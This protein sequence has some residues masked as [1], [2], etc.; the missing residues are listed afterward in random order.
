MT[1]CVANGN[2]QVGIQAGSG[3]TINACAAYDNGTV[4]IDAS[5]GTTV[6]NCGVYSNGTDGI[7]ASLACVIKNNSVYGNTEDDIEVTTDCLVMNNTC[8]SAGFNTGD[9]AGIHVTSSRNRIE[10]NNVSLCDRGIQVAQPNNVI[11]NNSVTRNPTTGTAMNYVIAA[12]NQVEILLTFLPETISIPATVRLSGDL[13]GI[14]GSAGLT[15]NSDS[16]TVDLAGHGLVGVAGSLDGIAVSGAHKNIVIKNGSAHSWGGAGINA[17]SSSNGRFD[18]LELTDNILDG[19][20]AG[21][22][23]VVTDCTAQ[24]NGSHGIEAGIIATIARCLAAGN[25]GSGI[26]V[27]ET[28][29]IEK[30]NL[31]NNVG[32]GITV[33]NYSVVRDNVCDFHPT[34]PGIF[35]AG[36]DNRIEGNNVTRNA[37]GIDIGAAGNFIIK[38]SAT[39]STGAG[40]PSANYDFNGFVQTNGAI[41]TTV[42]TIAA[43]AWANFSY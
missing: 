32:G 6:T 20:H 28:A 34:N 16:V 7:D 40:T 35:V 41:V 39:G 15:I 27:S 4:G 22:R 23:C 26:K 14:S 9:G 3:S 33:S 38:N 31:N 24:G 29:M 36:T 12:G 30:C 21:D 25:S 43:D 17:N 10:D 1:N 42:G 11:R 5:F 13:T 2:T 37:R 19:L 8:T 18:R